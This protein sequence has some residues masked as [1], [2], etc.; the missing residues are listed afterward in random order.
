MQIA[1]CVGSLELILLR[2]VK[3]FMCELAI[4]SRAGHLEKCRTESLRPLDIA[5]ST[6]VNGATRYFT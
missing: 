1:L 5:V 6:F 3:E 4:T 2:V